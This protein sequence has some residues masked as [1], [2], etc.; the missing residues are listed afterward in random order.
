MRHRGGVQ[1]F[2]G[3]QGLQHPHAVVAPFHHRIVEHQLPFC[4]ELD[5]PEP[6]EKRE[7]D[8]HNRLRYIISKYILKT[9]IL[10]LHNLWGSVR[11]FQGQDHQKT[12]IPK[13]LYP[14]D[15]H[16]KD[17]YPKDLNPKDMYPKDLYPK[18]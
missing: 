8:G 6:E 18:D 4:A 1:Q 11:V 15:L 10:S 13:D 3:R 17:L 7:R 9:I 12:C 14:K 5:V 16:P 2:R